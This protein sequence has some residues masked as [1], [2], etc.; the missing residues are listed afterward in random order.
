VWTDAGLK[1]NA[2]A[3]I[4]CLRSQRINDGD[5]AREVSYECFEF[6]EHEFLCTEMTG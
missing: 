1:R 4:C 3:S 2:G 6:N 5:A